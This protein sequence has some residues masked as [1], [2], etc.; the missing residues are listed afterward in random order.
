MRPFTSAAAAAST[1]V[2]LTGLL[3]SCSKGEVPDLPEHVCWGAFAGSDV[4]PA[5]PPGDKATWD[6]RPFLLTADHDGTTCRVYVDGNRSFQATAYF[7]KF[8]GSINWAPWDRKKPKPLNVGDKGIIWDTGA[9]AYFT[10]EPSKNPNTPG[11]YIEL[12]ITTHNSPDESK[13]QS[14]LPPLMKQFVTF[15]QRELKCPAGATS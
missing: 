5:L 4:S 15:A 6:H 10:C 12:L 7:K 9:T 3:T 11:K 1:V 14:V 2:I 13:V 8:E